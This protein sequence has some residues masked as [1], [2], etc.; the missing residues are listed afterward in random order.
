[1]TG[2]IVR[3]ER[4]AAAD[5]VAAARDA[6]V[7]GAGGAGFPTY[8]KWERIDEVDALLMNHQESEPNYFIDKWLGRE[9][10]STFAS[11][12]E[13]L[14][15]E[16]L[17]VVVV[18]AKW[19]DRDHLRTLERL[20]D[21]V[22]Y[23]PDQLPVDRSEESG[24]VFAYTDNTYQYGM[25]SVLLNV[26]A[27][28]VIGDG[29]PMDHGWLVQNTETLYNVYRAW[30]EGAPVTRTYVHVGGNVPQHRF[31]DVP[32]GTPAQTLL[33]AAGLSD[34]ELA[35]DSVLVTGGPGWCFPVDAAPEAVGVRKHTNCLM[36]LDRETVDQHTLGGDRIDVLEATDWT[37][38]AFETEPSQRI[39]PETV[40]V[41]LVTNPDIGVVE[42]SEPTVAVGQTVEA[43]DR[44]AAPSA[45]G[46][47]IPQHASVDGRVT[48]VGETS[49]TIRTE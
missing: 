22:V 35:P 24:V 37:E 21:G 45:T 36:V 38:R 44:I 19:K 9:H 11:L 25:E 20:T 2:T 41:P 48:A 40:H 8:S 49:I 27:D 12:F 17:D 10:P 39:D 42:P 16:L 34:G 13:V 18:S 4:P 3:T 32:V 14:L 28:T 31:L 6:G 46:V 30:T 5:I 33:N 47:S 15:E 7:A 43:G 23:S 1:M 26:V 29:L